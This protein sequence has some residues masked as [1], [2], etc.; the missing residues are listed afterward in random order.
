MAQRHDPEERTP[1]P[2]LLKNS[3]A[4]IIIRRASRKHHVTLV[5]NWEFIAEWITYFRHAENVLYFI[6]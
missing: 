1:Y 3:E 4:R 2:T 5:W 6:S